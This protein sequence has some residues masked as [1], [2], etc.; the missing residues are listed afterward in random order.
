MNRI[1]WILLVFFAGLG[2]VSCYSSP[3]PPSKLKK[4]EKDKSKKVAP[5]KAPPKKIE[6]P[7]NKVEKV[8]DKNWEAKERGRKVM[9]KNCA[10]C[11]RLI[12]PEELSAEA[13]KGVIPNM[14]QQSGL[15]QQETD[16][17]EMYILSVVNSKEK[18]KKK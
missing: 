18:K 4:S 14:A 9:L 13:W 5:E 3:P 2:V 17:M 12:P 1:P 10:D 15:T 7:K 8:K 11:H 16:E 6:P